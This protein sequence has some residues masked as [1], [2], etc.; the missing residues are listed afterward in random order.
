M[1]PLKKLVRMRAGRRLSGRN[2][3]L[4]ML[5][6][7]CSIAHTISQRLRTL[8]KIPPELMP[9]GKPNTSPSQTHNLTKAT[10]QASF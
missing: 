6:D 2:T 3:C 7:T 5:I 10:N 1:I 9:L 4:V 8:K